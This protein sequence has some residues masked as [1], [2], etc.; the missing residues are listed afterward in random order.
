[1]LDPATM[2]RLRRAGLA[3][4]LWHEERE[5]ELRAMVALAPD[6]ICTDTPAVLRSIVDADRASRMR[7]HLCH[8]P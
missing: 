5:D 2:Q 4:T 7:A 6:A 1:L 8:D 3:I